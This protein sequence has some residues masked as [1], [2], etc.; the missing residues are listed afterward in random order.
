MADN[1]KTDGAR[2]QILGKIK[3]AVRAEAR[4]QDQTAALEERLAAQRPGRVPAR[5]QL[6]PAER[7]DLFQAMAEELSTTVERLAGPDEVPAAVARYLKDQNLPARLRLAPDPEIAGLPW[8]REAL[9]EVEAGRAEA[10]DQASV[11]GALA[12]VAETGTLLLCSGPDS[13]TT[14]NF[15]PDTHI[16]VLKADR[17][18]GP[19]EEA[20][21]KVRARYGPG[22]L[23]RTVNLI[24]GPSRTADIEQTIQLGAHG[25]RRLHILLLEDGPAGDG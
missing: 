17:V 8:D 5:G 24:T 15:L 6:S 16:V 19:F 13:P 9:L 10:S 20:W 21:E 25:P 12:G 2:Q 18:V 14:L 1:A 23:P 22:V 7:L 4:D 3:R 11:T